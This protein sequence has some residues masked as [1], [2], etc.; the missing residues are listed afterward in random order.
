[1][2][3]RAALVNSG[4]VLGAVQTFHALREKREQ[5]G[6]LSLAEAKVLVHLREVVVALQEPVPLGSRVAVSIA[7][8]GAR[9]WFRFR[10]RVVAVDP[11]TSDTTVLL[12]STVG[13]AHP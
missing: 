12:L 13:G 2:A 7:G 6:F 4:G 3:A 9:R 8:P 5:S 1:M 10:G 11:E